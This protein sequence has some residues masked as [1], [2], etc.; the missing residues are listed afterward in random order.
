MLL[1]DRIVMVSGIGPG[2]GVKL[3]VEA[4]REG[5]AGVVLAARTASRLDDAQCRIEALG[6]GTAVLRHATDIT[7]TSDCEGLVA[8]TLERFGR[9]DA[10]VNSAYLHGASDR[11]STAQLDDWRPVFD[12]NLLGTLRLTQQVLAPMRAQGS[13][14]I[15]MINTLIAR[16]V[17]AL[18]GAGYAASKAALANAVKYLATEVGRDGIRVNS[19]HL[20]FMWGAPTEAYFTQQ[21]QQRGVPVEQL[22][23]RMADSLPLRRVPTDEECARAALFLVSDHA[24]AITGAALDVNGGAYMP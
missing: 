11:V 22:R 5:A 15:V 7:R 16:Q 13:G 20:G 2:L 1:K 6:L 9:I 14:A 10:L 21:A 23:Q 17:A 8:A 18:G 19:V 24:S 3:A 12:T 4:A